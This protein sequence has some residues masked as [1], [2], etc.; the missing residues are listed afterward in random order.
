[1]SKNAEGV[2]TVRG[3]KLEVRSKFGRIAIIGAAGVGKTTFLDALFVK[4]EIS[5]SF[6]KIEEIVRKLSRER[7]YE[8][9]YAINEDLDQFRHDVLLR[10]IAEEN[11]ADRFIVD[12]STIDAWAYYMRWSWNTSSVERAEEFYELAYKQAKNYDLL[13]YLPIMF[14]L[15]DDGFRWNNPIY[16]KQIDRLLRSIINDWGLKDKVYE[17]KS[18]TIDRRLQ[19]ISCLGF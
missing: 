1:M 13:I 6:T 7:G 5:S 8:S 16:Q 10:Q 14:E 9:P 4:Q 2:F 19:E 11:K 17:I 12:R 15:Q 18:E 3:S